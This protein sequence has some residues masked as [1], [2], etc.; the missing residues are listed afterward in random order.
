MF[1]RNFYNY[2][3]KDTSLRLYKSL[4][5]PHLE[6]ASAIW[7]P[8]LAKDIKSIEDV[9]KF[10]LRVCTKSWESDYNSLLLMCNVDLMSDRRKFAQLCLLFKII[11]GDASYPNPPYKQVTRQYPARHQNT[12]QFSV[13]YART[14]QFQSSFFPNTTSTWNGLN[15]DTRGISIE[16]FKSKLLSTMFNV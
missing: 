7:S 9:Q 3:T 16:T 13:Q 4:I 10:A 14:N 11:A 15:F 6:Y 1:Y 5:R 12:L 2:S 8:H